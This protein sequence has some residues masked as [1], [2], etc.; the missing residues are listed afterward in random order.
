MCFNAL[1][2]STEQDKHQKVHSRLH[3]EELAQIEADTEKIA[4]TRK[5]AKVT[6]TRRGI[7]QGVCVPLNRYI[8]S[9]FAHWKNSN[10][11]FKVAVNEKVKS[12]IIKAYKNRV[13]DAIEAWKKKAAKKKRKKRKMMSE[14]IESHNDAMQEE[15]KKVSDDIAVQEVRSNKKGNLKFKKMFK[16]VIDDELRYAMRRWKHMLDTKK[17]TAK[18]LE[19]T[20][21]IKMKKRLYGEAFQKYR[22]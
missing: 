14:S 21:L 15:I 20:V 3:G 10:R 9:Y 1:K 17:D 4:S 19:S 12:L 18:K 7:T 13:A 22:D 11:F 6:Q 8:H 5:R 2:L 16:K